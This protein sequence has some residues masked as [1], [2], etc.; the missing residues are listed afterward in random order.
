MKLNKKGTRA[1]YEKR[2]WE[3]L[4]ITI[5]YF[6]E[7]EV[8]SFRVVMCDQPKLSPEK[9]LSTFVKTPDFLSN[10]SF[11]NAATGDSIMNLVSDGTVFSSYGLDDE[12]GVGVI[13][14]DYSGHTDAPILGKFCGGDYWRDFVTAYPVLIRGDALLELSEYGDINYTA[15]RMAFG[16]LTH[17]PTNEAWYFFLLVEGEGCRLYELQSIICD[18]IREAGSFEVEWAI[19]LDGGGSAYLAVEG[20]RVSEGEQGSWQRAVDNVIAVWL[21]DTQDE[22]ETGSDADQEEPDA[23]QKYWRVSL[24]AFSVKDNAYRYLDVIRSLGTGVVDYGKAFVSYDE[25]KKLYR[26]QV[27][28]FS[29]RDGA[30]KVAAELNGL[31]YD[32]YVRYS[33]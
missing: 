19:N 17:M 24:G 10:G 8:E 22:G 15:Q 28:A 33:E 32:T 5:A 27:G 23:P 4:P 14:S 21:K 2:T 13:K 9:M 11:F 6:P 1:H 31:G 29:R 12:Y 30:A 26:V 18:E 7:C 20:K 3:D 16:K 25:A